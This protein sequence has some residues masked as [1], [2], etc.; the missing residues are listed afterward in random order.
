MFLI[1]VVVVVVV[2]VVPMA[3]GGYGVTRGGGVMYGEEE[4]FANARRQVLWSRHTATATMMS[5]AELKVAQRLRTVYGEHNHAAYKTYGGR[6]GGG[7]QEEAVATVYDWPAALGLSS[8]ALLLAL[9]VSLMVHYGEV[10]AG[11]AGASLCVVA[12][13]AWA[14]SVIRARR[15]VRIAER[16]AAELSDEQRCVTETEAERS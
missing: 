10:A 12:G 8:L 11:A 7:A 13:G 16:A 3:A 9:S 14:A 1:I 5:H 15:D 2:V 4:R 6:R